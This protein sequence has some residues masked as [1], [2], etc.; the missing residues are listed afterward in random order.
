[1][2][3]G[4]ECVFRLVFVY[5]EDYFLFFCVVRCF[6]LFFRPFSVGGAVRRDSK[7]SHSY[8]N[9]VFERWLSA[10]TDARRMCVGLVAQ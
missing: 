1:M 9:E 7:K 10:G 2:E 8:K 4:R 3:L 6:T 5:D